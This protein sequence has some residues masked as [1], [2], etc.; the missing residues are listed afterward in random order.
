MPE[1]SQGK[2]TKNRRR[3]QT[4]VFRRAGRL[5]QGSHGGVFMPHSQCLSQYRTVTPRHHRIDLSLESPHHDTARVLTGLVHVDMGIG[6]VADQRG[7]VGDDS[8]G[9]VG[10]EIETHRNRQVRR[11]LTDAFQ[12]GALTIHRGLGHHGPVQVEKTNVTTLRDRLADGIAH[13][14]VRICLDPATGGRMTGDRGLDLHAFRLRDIEKCAK[15]G[16]GAL[17][18]AIDVFAG[19]NPRAAESTER[20]RHRR[21]GIGLVLHH[22]RHYTPGH[23]HS[24]RK[25]IPEIAT[26]RHPVLQ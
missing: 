1:I 24:S 11:H 10:V 12:Q 23:A 20:G 25:D 3:Q 26:F 18:Q 16:T 9:Q 2:T 7:A 17:E 8:L 15:T 13:G 21:K 4:I 6:F 5:D 19:W 22:C 14:L